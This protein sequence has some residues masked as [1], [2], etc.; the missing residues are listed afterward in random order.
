MQVTAIKKRVLFFL[1]VN[2][3][4]LCVVCLIWENRYPFCIACWNNFDL[5]LK[6]SSEKS[7]L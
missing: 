3:L 1:S 5:F 6:I 7:Y 2:K 4:K